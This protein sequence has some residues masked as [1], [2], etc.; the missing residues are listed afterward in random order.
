MAREQDLPSSVQN[1]LSASQRPIAFG[2]LGEPSGVPAW[3]TL[4]SWYVVG[5]VDKVILEATQI[6]MAT[7]AGSKITMVKAS[8]LPA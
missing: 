5:T 6:Q 1:L 8:H 4:P 3:K 2:T 7:A